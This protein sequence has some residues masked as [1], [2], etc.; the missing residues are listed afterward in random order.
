MPAFASVNRVDAQILSST[1]KGHGTH[2]CGM[3]IVFY[4]DF[5]L[6]IFYFCRKCSNYP[7]Q[8]ITFIKKF[9]INV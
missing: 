6:F 3:E 2:G 1:P 9:V 5:I 7:E 4:H 8:S